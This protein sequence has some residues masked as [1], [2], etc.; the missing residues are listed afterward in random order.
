M[1]EGALGV[2][3]SRG[4]ACGRALG[5]ETGAGGR[6]VRMWGVSFAMSPLPIL[7]RRVASSTRPRSVLVGLGASL[8]GTSLGSNLTCA[9][10]FSLSKLKTL[11][12][13][14]TSKNLA[15]LPGSGCSWAKLAPINRTRKAPKAAFRVPATSGRGRPFVPFHTP[16]QRTPESPR[17]PERSSGSKH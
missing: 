15:L 2:C 12:T 11:S 16:E 6:V 9:S 8:E 7:D 17:F 13:T 3:L 1:G 14:A 5:Q 4:W 10:T